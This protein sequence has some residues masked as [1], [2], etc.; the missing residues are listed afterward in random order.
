MLRTSRNRKR[1]VNVSGNTS[2]ALQKE[3]CHFKTPKAY[4]PDNIS[5]DF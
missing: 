3:I 5:S 4:I 1:R 2:T